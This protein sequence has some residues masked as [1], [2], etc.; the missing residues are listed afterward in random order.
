MRSET[1]FSSF[2]SADDSRI[3]ICA[4]FILLTSNVGMARS[5]AD[6]SRLPSA[7]GFGPLASV[8]VRRGEEY[9][10]RPA[11]ASAICGLGLAWRGADSATHTFKHPHSRHNNTF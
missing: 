3:I 9:Q 1:S 6:S 5:F 4:G 11:E 7:A 2:T 8:A 10:N